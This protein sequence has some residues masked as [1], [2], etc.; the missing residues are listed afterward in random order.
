MNESKRWYQSKA[1]WGS[2]LGIAILGAELL[3]IT[4]TQPDDQ[5]A[6]TLALVAAAVS[7]IG[8][9]FAKTKLTK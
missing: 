7:L 1:F 6:E 2:A 4:P 9:L 8:R 3:G 5:T